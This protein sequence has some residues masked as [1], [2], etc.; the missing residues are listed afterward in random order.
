MVGGNRKKQK[1]RAKQA[2]KQAQQVP[3]P[4]AEDST[5]LGYDEDALRYDE[6]E[7]YSDEGEPEEF[8]TNLEHAAARL[9]EL[10]TFAVSLE[11]TVHNSNAPAWYPYEPDSDEDYSEHY[12]IFR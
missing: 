7:D 5:D 6:E 10:N 11:F 3:M 12:R 8:M 4:P 2:A 9:E 1:R